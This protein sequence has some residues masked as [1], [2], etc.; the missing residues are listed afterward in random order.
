MVDKKPIDLQTLI[1]TNCTEYLDQCI[2]SAINPFV[3]FD[4]LPV[5]INSNYQTAICN[6]NRPSTA[7]NLGL[8]K[9]IAKDYIQLLDSDDFLSEKYFDAILPILS[10]NPDFDLFYTDYTILN[11]DFGFS[12]RE[13][14]KSP[15]NSTIKETAPR[16]KNPIVR[17]SI[18][19]KIKFDE[20]LSCFEL[21]DLIYKIGP[22]KL[23]HHPYDMQ[24]VRIHPKC[25]ARTASKAQRDESMNIIS[26]RINGKV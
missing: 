17:T 9:I 13:Y 11:E 21:V 5:P 8:S 18:L 1:V 20:S 6:V 22:S 7:R 16:I 25:F 10:Q 23:Y 2:D 24:S 12:N 14:L 3:V 15:S 26:G 4:G 19:K